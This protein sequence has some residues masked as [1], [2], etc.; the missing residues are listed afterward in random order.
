MTVEIKGSVLGEFSFSQQ[1]ELIDISNKTSSKF[2]VPH[3]R[4]QLTFSSSDMEPI[5]KGDVLTFNGVT[6]EVTEVG[7]GYIN[8]L[9]TNEYT[10]NKA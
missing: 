9:T 10:N 8:G 1:G 7:D 3:K 4:V 2:P 6:F 5:F